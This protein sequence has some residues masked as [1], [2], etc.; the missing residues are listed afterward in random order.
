MP[1]LHTL[2]CLTVVVPILAH[3]YVQERRKLVKCL[4]CESDLTD[5]TKPE[6]IF[7]E[8]FDKY[9]IPDGALVGDAALKPI[10]NELRSGWPAGP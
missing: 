9:G 3:H 2:R 8:A 1:P 10:W 6:R 7:D 5:D 4:F